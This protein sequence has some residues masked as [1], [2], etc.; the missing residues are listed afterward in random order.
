MFSRFCCFLGL[1]F[2]DTFILTCKLVGSRFF[3]SYIWFWILIISWTT[4]FANFLIILGSPR[5]SARTGTGEKNSPWRG[6]GTGTGGNLGD[7]EWESTS[8]PTPL[9]FLTVWRR[10][11]PEGCWPF[12]ATVNGGLLGWKW[13]RIREDKLVISIFKRFGCNPFFL[14]LNS[15]LTTSFC[16]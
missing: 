6:T 4:V 2:F 12:S 3:H 8:R 5:G 16:I 9:T 10:G 11:F 7:G 15:I 13:V 14:L 1:V